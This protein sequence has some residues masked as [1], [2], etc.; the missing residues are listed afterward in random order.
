MTILA[1]ALSIGAFESALKG[2]TLLMK[3]P[4]SL[5]SASMD[6]QVFNGKVSDGI[7]SV[8]KNDARRDKG[9]VDLNISKSDIFKDH[10]TLGGAPSGS[11]KR[12]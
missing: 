10:T 2:I 3:R 4:L 1:S 7:G 6:E 11:R 5:K 9:I 12:V 8:T